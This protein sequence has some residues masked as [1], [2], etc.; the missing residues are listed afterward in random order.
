MGGGR[1][2]RQ[3]DGTGA[4]GEAAP[5]E[6]FNPEPAYPSSDVGGRLPFIAHSLG[7]AVHDTQS[8]EAEMLFVDGGRDEILLFFTEQS[9]PLPSFRHSRRTRSWP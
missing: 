6:E 7:V 2:K 8:K 3:L 9:T 5:G 4:N 1:R